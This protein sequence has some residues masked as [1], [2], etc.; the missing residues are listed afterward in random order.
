[1]AH[2]DHGKTVRRWMLMSWEQANWF[3]RTAESLLSPPFSAEGY[4]LSD[5]SR[6]TVK[7]L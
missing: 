1:M 4:D 7:T 5:P 2:K 6:S 3:K